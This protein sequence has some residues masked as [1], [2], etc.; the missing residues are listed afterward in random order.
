[1]N[2]ITRGKKLAE[3]LRGSP[4]VVVGIVRVVE[5]TH[6]SMSQLQQGEI[7]VTSR[8]EPAFTP[9][10]KRARG[11]V[12]DQGGM[13]SHSAIVAR[14]MGM[15]AVVGAIN[16]TQV[17]QDGMRV[18]VDGS[19]GAVYEAIGEGEPPAA[20]IEE[21]AKKYGVTLSSDFREKLDRLKRE[22]RR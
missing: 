6:A 14:E 5:D 2:P 17:L 13:G 4:G 12:T 8:T 7:M 3:G 22:M 1:M 20:G 11:I 16:A 10:M 9:Y 15:P 18:V 21:T 19:E